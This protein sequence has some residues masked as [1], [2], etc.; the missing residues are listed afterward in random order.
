MTVDSIVGSVLAVS[1]FLGI[2]RFLKLLRFNRKTGMLASVMKNSA[3]QWPGF[4]ALSAVFFIAFIHI[5][6]VTF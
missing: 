4:I 3:K 6:L 2:I 1:A 5:G